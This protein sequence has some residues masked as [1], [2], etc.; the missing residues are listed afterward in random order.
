MSTCGRLLLRLLSLTHVIRAVQPRGFTRQIGHIGVF[1]QLATN[2]AG[3]KPGASQAKLPCLCDMPG[4]IH[5]LAFLDSSIPGK[6]RSLP[7]T[8]PEVLK[9]LYSPACNV[10]HVCYLQALIYSPLH[11]HHTV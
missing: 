8:A 5:K 2:L 4:R 11:G 3:R 7:G 1:A 9:A 6:T 10:A